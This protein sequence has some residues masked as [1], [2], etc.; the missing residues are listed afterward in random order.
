MSTFLSRL[1]VLVTGGTPFQIVSDG[2]NQISETA[3]TGSPESVVT[4]N[5]GSRYINYADGSTWTKSSGTGN[6]GWSLVEI[7]THPNHTG[8]VTSA[9]DGATTI[10]ANAVTSDKI[11]NG[12]VTNAKL[13]DVSTATI[14]GRLSAGTG[15]VEDLTATQ[16]RSILNVADGANNYVHPNHT[17]DVTSTGDG[18][19]VIA[20]NAVT[21]TKIADNAITGAKILNG[22]IG[23]PKIVDAAVGNAKLADMPGGTV[24]ARLLGGGT[25]MPQDLTARQTRG[26]LRGTGSVDLA[27]SS[28]INFSIEDGVYRR[29]AANGN[30]TLNFPGGSIIGGETVFIY[31]TSIIASTITLGAGYQVPAGHSVTLSGAGKKD[32]LELTLDTPTTCTVTIV[33][34]IA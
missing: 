28:T 31:V 30:F 33:K 16:A 23:G 13:A 11:L 4:A 34:D 1:F 32:R 5:P 17:G 24:K 3:G 12:A 29:I 9:G 2:T 21:N 10:A 26:L 7:Y 14:K 18:A 25:G 15:L 27:F 6:T 20:D 19:T 8:D 22:T